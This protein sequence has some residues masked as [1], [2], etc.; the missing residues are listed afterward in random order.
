[1]TVLVNESGASIYSASPVA[2]EEFPDLDL[3][4][5]GAISIARRLQD[6]LA[7]LVKLE[8]RHVGVGQYQ[9]DVNQK[10]LREGLTKTVEF[11]V[12]RVGVDLN[13]AAAE[14]LRY[15]SGIQ[16]NTA[17]NIVEFRQNNGPFMNRA[18]LLEVSG[19]GGRTYGQCAGFLRIQNGAEPL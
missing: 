17:T 8:P 14:L 13:T 19:V 12:N 10:N 4:I 15:I 5:R 2:R 7:E 1:T 3:T 9:H 11:C 6:P 18:Q 16:Q